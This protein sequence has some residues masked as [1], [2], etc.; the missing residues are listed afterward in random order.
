MRSDHRHWL[1]AMLGVLALALG[2]AGCGGEEEQTEAPTKEPAAQ[3][4]ERY[5]ANTTMG[6]IQQKGQITIGV[7]FDVPPFGF[8]NP[9]TGDVEGFDVDLGKAY[10]DALGVRPR[11]VEA[12]SDNR[13]P[14]IKDGTVDLVLS[15]MTINAER[16][17]EIGFTNPYFIAHGRILVPEDSDISGIDDLAGKKVCTALGSTYEET[18]KEQAPRADLRLVDAYSECLENLQNGAVAAISTDDVILTGM[19]MQD[20]S[21]KL[22]GEELTTEPYGGG[23][24]KGDTEF[25]TFLNNVLDD[26][27]SDGRWEQAY[28]K[29][30]GRHTG[31]D[32]DPPTQTLAD[33]L[34]DA[35]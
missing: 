6:R 11:F 34:R 19:I 3:N 30:L 23:F 31:E 9:R 25:A 20:D 13:I 15:T 17:E 27:K 16:A 21:L 18:L 5:A 7:K 10:A 35:S 1:V 32:A 26:Y 2:G 14:F 22:V 8:K 29:W 12:I 24:K 28:Q 33:V 4:V